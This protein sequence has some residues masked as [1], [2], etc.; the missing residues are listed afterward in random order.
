MR[1]TSPAVV[2]ETF[3]FRE[4]T[5]HV[6]A[7]DKVRHRPRACRSE[8]VHSRLCRLEQH[9]RVAVAVQLGCGVRCHFLEISAVLVR[10]ADAENGVAPARLQPKNLT[11][12]QGFH[13][14]RNCR[15]REWQRGM[16]HE[17]A[18]FA[19]RSSLVTESVLHFSDH[20]RLGTSKIVVSHRNAKLPY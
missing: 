5:L 19:I 10:F 18:R 6:I 7:T 3:V 14:R 16:V 20:A 11:L 8:R 9:L 4:S 2:S 12:R 17:Y 15:L 1:P 13:Y